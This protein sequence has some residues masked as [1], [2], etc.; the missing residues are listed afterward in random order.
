MVV[1]AFR[2]GSKQGKCN[3]TFKETQMKSSIDQLKS[4][5]YITIE[6]VENHMNHTKSEW[7]AMIHSKEAYQRTIAVKLLS[8]KSDVDDELIQLFLHR[9]TQEKKLYTKIE[10]C[11]ALAKG[12]VQSAKLMVN[13]LGQ[14]GN[15]QYQALPTKAFNKNSYPL[16][17]DIIARTLAH[18]N[19]NVLPVLLDVLKTNRLPEIRE[20]IDAI[21]FICFYN[22]LHT[23]RQISDLLIL[24][25]Q[26]YA[27][28]D[29]IRWKLVRSFE[30]FDASDVIH[31]LVNIEQSDCEQ[32]I[33][34]EARRSLNIISERINPL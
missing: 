7:L 16:P 22:N 18:M 5:G 19:P 23:N 30:S 2:L 14:I 9:L 1:T 3:V 33:R 24:C 15:N 17:R 12:G 26:N 4:R 13:Y 28:D 32:I 10:L 21:G 11:D 8:E 25:L 31:T 20:V 29:V 27:H 34:R 6:N